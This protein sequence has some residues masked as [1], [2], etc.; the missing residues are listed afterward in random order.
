VPHS[1]LTPGEITFQAR[2]AGLEVMHADP[3]I[4]F[5]GKLLEDLCVGPHAARRGQLVTIYGINRTL[6]YQ[7]SYYDSARDQYLMCWPD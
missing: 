6:V 4:Y 3:V 1:Q 2:T 5:D 7:I